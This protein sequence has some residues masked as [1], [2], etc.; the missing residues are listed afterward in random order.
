M[1]ITYFIS[2]R[3]KSYTQESWTY[4][5]S[6]ID[7][8]PFVWLA[9]ADTQLIKTVLINFQSISLEE[10]ELFRQTVANNGKG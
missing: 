6:V 7:E 1:T 3:H 5:C 10:Y 8:H 9:K 2:Y 4:D